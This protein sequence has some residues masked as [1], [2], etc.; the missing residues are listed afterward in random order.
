MQISNP[1]RM[2][3]ETTYCTLVK[4]K[5]SF[6]IDYVIEMVYSSQDQN[7]ETPVPYTKHNNDLFMYCLFLYSMSMW[8][9][10]TRLPPSP[11]HQKTVLLVHQAGKSLTQGLQE[12]PKSTKAPPV[13]NR[14]YLPEVETERLLQALSHRLP[15]KKVIRNETWQGKPNCNV[16]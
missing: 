2:D 14:V 5:S 12:A 15:P 3:H 7:W 8:P 4:T 6:Q 13:D 1:F 16:V 9:E 10:V 11:E